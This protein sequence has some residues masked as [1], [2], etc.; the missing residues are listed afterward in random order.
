MLKCC[1]R[2]I[3]PSPPPNVATVTEECQHIYY[4]AQSKSINIRSL[5]QYKKSFYVDQTTGNKWRVKTCASTECR[6]VQKMHVPALSDRWCYES[7]H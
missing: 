1:K 7:S 2:T 5:D 6:D 4:T 3:P